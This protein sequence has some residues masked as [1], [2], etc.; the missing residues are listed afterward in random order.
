M[1]WSDCHDHHPRTKVLQ[2]VPRPGSVL[3]RSCSRTRMLT[4]FMSFARPSN[5]PPSVYGSIQM[6]QNS[7]EKEKSNE[8]LICCNGSNI[9]I[10][11]SASIWACVQNESTQTPCARF[12]Q[13]QKKTRCSNKNKGT[14]R[15]EREREREK[16]HRGFTC[17]TGDSVVACVLWA[18]PSSPPPPSYPPLF[19]PLP[20]SFLPAPA[21]A[22]PS[23][24]S[25][26]TG[27]SKT[28]RNI[29]RLFTGCSPMAGN[30]LRFVCLF[31]CFFSSFSLPFHPSS[32]FCCFSHVCV[33][34]YRHILAHVHI[35]TQTYTNTCSCAHIYTYTYLHLL[36]ICTYIHI[37]THVHTQTHIHAHMYTH[38]YFYTF[39]HMYTHTHIHGVTLVQACRCP[40]L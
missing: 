2:T 39:L 4:N 32:S 16:N 21:P 23:P 10:A 20:L 29:Q 35:R 9:I 37:L 33:L 40:T 30:P 26:L 28:T 15:R 31:L 18:F 19:P 3:H 12:I 38:L 8:I 25:G 17:L 14:R 36:L 6:P 27:R 11:T 13:K 1:H 24:P 7:I 22:P 5:E 34:L